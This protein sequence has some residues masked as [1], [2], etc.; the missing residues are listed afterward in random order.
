ML[1]EYGPIEPLVYSVTY[2]SVIVMA[3]PLFCPLLPAMMPSFKFNLPCG[4]MKI[5]PAKPNPP[6]ASLLTM[7]PPFNLN[8][9]KSSSFLR[10]GLVVEPPRPINTAPAAPMLWSII[11]LFIV[12]FAL[13]S[14][15]TAPAVYGKPELSLLVF[16]VILPPFILNSDP[17][18][19]FIL[20][21]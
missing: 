21:E 15:Y 1:F 20:A 2:W 16:A 18:C 13:G 9:A 3:P 7:F 17:A 4:K 8:K 14:I 10:I 19:N 5:P 11:P 6:L 12:N